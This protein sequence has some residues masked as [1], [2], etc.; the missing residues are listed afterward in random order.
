MLELGMGNRDPTNAACPLPVLGHTSMS[1]LLICSVIVI[2]FLVFLI[3]LITDLIML[4]FGYFNFLLLF[5][6]GILFFQIVI[7]L[8]FGGIGGSCSCGVCYSVVGQLGFFIT[9]S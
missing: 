1:S 6:I 3:V 2:V 9:L 8:L 4:L 7:F 5:V